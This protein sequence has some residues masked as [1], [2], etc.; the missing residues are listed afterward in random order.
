MAGR[1][2]SVEITSTM[3]PVRVDRSFIKH[4]KKLAK[5]RKCYVSDLVAEALKAHYGEELKAFEAMQ[6]AK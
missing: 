6:M 2:K 3:I 4:M 5:K 1:P